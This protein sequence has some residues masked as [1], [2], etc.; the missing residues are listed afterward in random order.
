MLARN[1]AAQD[2]TNGRVFRLM[3]RIIPTTEQRHG[4]RF[5]AR[6]A[7]V[8]KATPFFLVLVLVEL[9]D[10]VFAVDSILAIFAITADP[11]I[12]FTS[13]VFAVMGLRSLFFLLAN[14]A[15]RFVY[16]QPGLALV[17]IFVG[18]KMAISEWLK[19]PVEASLAVVA[20][21]LIGSIVASLWKSRASGPT[22]SPRLERAPTK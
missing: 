14:V 12:V 1:D 6:E 17:L 20:A 2:P 15:E 5:F 19:I 3:K 7:G 10:V 8:L 22:P 16:L 9:S 18:T 21:L 11:F 4:Q 13:N